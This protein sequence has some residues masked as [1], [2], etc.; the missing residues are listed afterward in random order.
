MATDQPEPGLSSFQRW[1]LEDDIK[2]YATF[3]QAR[4]AANQ[5]TFQTTQYG[6]Y[7]G[8]AGFGFNL[9]RSFAT[10]KTIT[11]HLS[12]DHYSSTNNQTAPAHNRGEEAKSSLSPTLHHD[13]DPVP[14]DSRISPSSSH[15]YRPLILYDSLIHRNSHNHVPP[16]QP[17]VSPSV[18]LLHAYFFKVIHRCQSLHLNLITPMPPSTNRRAT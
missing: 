18:Y 5:Y 1:K 7:F 10:D 13:Y 11:G 14:D 17:G 4:P 12:D 16:T 2:F 3:P 15:T 6:D 8:G 9:G